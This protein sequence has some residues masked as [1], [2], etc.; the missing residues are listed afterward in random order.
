MGDTEVLCEKPEPYKGKIPLGSLDIPAALGL[1]ISTSHG[2]NTYVTNLEQQ[3]PGS[4]VSVDAKGPL[5][6][7]IQSYFTAP[8]AL[9]FERSFGVK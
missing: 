1:A 3:A 4:C 7:H 2:P 8:G 9:T 5:D 6:F